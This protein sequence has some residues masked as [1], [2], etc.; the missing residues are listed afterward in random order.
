MRRYLLVIL[1][2]LI[3]CSL[4]PSTTPL[5]PAT[6]RDAT[7]SPSP[8]PAPTETLVPSP[9]AGAPPFVTS[10]P[11][12]S[13]F[14]WTRLPGDFSRPVDLQDLGDG[15]L[16]VV[17]QAGTI[18][19]HQ[20]GEVLPEPFLDLR[21]RVGVVANE[22]GLLGL[23][24]HPDYAS[25]GILFVNYTDLDGDTVISRFQASADPGRAD[26]SSE[27]VLI[28][29]DQPYPNHNGG[30]MVFGPDGYLYIGSGDGGSAGDPHGNGQRL[31]TFLG[32]ILRIDVNGEEPYSIPPDNPFP[33]RPEIWAYGLRNPW[34]FAFDPLTSD[35][36]I[37]DVGQ[38]DWEEV[39]FQPA[40]APGGANYGWNILEGTHPY[41]GG[42]TDALTPPI[43]E[44]S[45]DFG[46]SITGGVVARDPGLAEF[47]GVYLYSD[48][49]SGLV[50]GLVRD[51]SGAW[52][53]ALLFETGLRISSFGQGRSGEIYLLDLGG[54][55]YR[56]ERAAEPAP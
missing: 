49:C 15:R 55:V 30:G 29:F 9:T 4:T 11:D 38:R 50:W 27:T 13:A 16:L 12:P 32:K 53:N 34:R 41:A 33:S 18:M 8:A 25:N 31:D 17:Q 39:N 56:L 20:N 51:T 46:C 36:Y 21:D 7:A 37:A 52:Q 5:A 40:G 48:Y 47:T 23:A 28:Q 42:G 14:V 35:L 2:L 45:H 10:F 3:A 54:A 1:P 44:Y 22:Q 24:L 43:A 26:A 6:H 19:I